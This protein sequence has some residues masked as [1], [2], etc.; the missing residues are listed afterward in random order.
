MWPGSLG[1]RIIDVGPSPVHI[2]IINILNNN[3]TSP[4]GCIADVRPS[5]VRV[6]KVDG[7]QV[8]EKEGGGEKEAWQERVQEWA[9]ESCFLFSCT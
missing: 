7:D 4:C 9:L 1:G 2:N 8:G 3:I 5:P 6:T